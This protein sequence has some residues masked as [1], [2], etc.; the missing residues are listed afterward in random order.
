ML[1]AGLVDLGSTWMFF[2]CFISPYRF[3][4]SRNSFLGSTLGFNHSDQHAG[5]WVGRFRVNLDVF[6]VFHIPL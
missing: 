5:S 1:V 2:M 3:L 4:G 6:D